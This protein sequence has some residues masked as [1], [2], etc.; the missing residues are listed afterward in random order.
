MFERL[1]IA[2]YLRA[3]LT[4]HGKSEREIE[5]VIRWYLP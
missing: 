4:K 5:A 1:V 2:A 3:L